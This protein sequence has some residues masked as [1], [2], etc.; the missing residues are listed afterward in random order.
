MTNNEFFKA[1]QKKFDGITPDGKIAAFVK[2]G[3]EL[4]GIFEIPNAFKAYKPDEG[5]VFESRDYA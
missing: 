4:V 5:L 3:W 2:A 1:M